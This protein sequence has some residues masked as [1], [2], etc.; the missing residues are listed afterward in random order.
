MDALMKLSMEE[1]WVRWKLVGDEKANQKMVIRLIQKCCFGM[2][3]NS[4][5]LRG[6]VAAPL[7]GNSF[8]THGHQQPI[9]T[10]TSPTSPSSAT[11]PEPH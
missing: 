2:E 4:V 5:E 10:P 3:T 7:S 8:P 6:R 11:A 1:E 9:H